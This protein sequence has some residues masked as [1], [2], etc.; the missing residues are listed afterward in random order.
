[1]RHSR[2]R[3][4]SKLLVS[5]LMALGMLVP[6]VQAL[7]AS[8]GPLAVEDLTAPAVTATGI[9]TSPSSG[10]PTQQTAS[11]TQDAGG[12]GL[13]V[14]MQQLQN[15]QQQLDQ[16][17]GEIEVLKHT[18]DQMQSSA[19]DRY[20]DLD[21]RIKALSEEATAKQPSV[22]N[23]APQGTAATTQSAQQ[24]AQKDQEAYVDARNKLLSGD[25]KGAASALE[26]YLKNYPKGQYAADAHYW[27]GEVYRIEGDQ[28]SLRKAA[29]QFNV[30]INHY[31][32]NDKIPAALYKLATVNAQQ[33]NTTAAKVALNRILQQFP[34]SGEASLAKKMLAAL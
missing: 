14:M 4:L 22:S 34:K 5:S 27:L 13:L 18:I 1:M 10:T 29:S 30:L 33:G 21:T 26:A 15:Y 9:N 17:R 25:H 16:L 11:G 12:S 19:K 20:M 3:V 7:G 28:A 2:F 6:S 32:G 23:S 8:T 24:S 31:P